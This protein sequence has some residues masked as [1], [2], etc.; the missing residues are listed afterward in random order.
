MTRSHQLAR[1]HAFGVASPLE[2]IFAFLFTISNVLGFWI[3]TIITEFQ[4]QSENGPRGLASHSRLGV[5]TAGPSIP[6][7]EGLNFKTI[8]ELVRS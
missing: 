8:I 4:F 3:C 6:T 7:A 5:G 1:S 2:Y